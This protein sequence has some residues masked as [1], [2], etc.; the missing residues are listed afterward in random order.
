MRCLS[1][2]PVVLS[3][4]VREPRYAQ[5]MPRSELALALAGGGARGAYQVGFLRHLARRHP[6]FPIEILTGVSAGAVNAV[7]LAN[8]TGRFAA[9]VED[10]TRAW[11]SLSVDRVFRVD[12][13]SL[14]PRSLRWVVQLGLLGGRRHIVQSKGLVD[15]APLR[16]FLYEA[17]GTRDGRLPGIAE[18]LDS[19]NLRAIAISTTHYASGST[20]AFCQGREVQTWERPQRHS[21]LRDLTVEHVMASAA[22]PFFF[23]AVDIGGQWFGDGSIRLHSPLAPAV[24]LGARKIIAVSTRTDAAQS[25]RRPLPPG[26]YP[27]PA[28]ILGVLFNSVFLDLLD[29]DALRLERINR[30]LAAG[31]GE[32]VERLRPVDLLILRPSTELGLIAS[33]YEPDLPKVF[34]FL[35]RRLGTRD[36]RGRDVLSMLMFQSDFL[37]RIIELGEADADARADEIAAF[38]EA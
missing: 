35:T 19:G 6:D 2:F 3:E 24:H 38:V 30:L 31:S 29:Q 28:Q 37:T 34:R 11:E 5:R 10:L 33:D 4:N 9:R 16:T 12:A 27:P 8:H 14:L 22:L 23:P 13:L 36:A 26:D 17:L 15:T 20:V 18:N 32:T 21:A 1:A 25:F 7:H